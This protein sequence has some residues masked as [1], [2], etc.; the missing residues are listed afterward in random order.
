MSAEG[1][2]DDTGGGG[3]APGSGSAERVRELEAKLAA[4]Q[5]SIGA[6]RGG[7]ALHEAQ[8]RIL[9]RIADGA[10]LAELFAALID[11]IETRCPG[12]RGSIL[13]VNAD[14][15]TLRPAAAPRMPAEF[16][17]LL[18]GLVIGPAAGSCGTACYRGETVITTDT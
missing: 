3:Q 6:L 18:E 11:V 10:P 16:L 17:H 1:G 4:A 9:E 15:R 12:M 13:L 2:A 8:R 7:A 14:G 5:A